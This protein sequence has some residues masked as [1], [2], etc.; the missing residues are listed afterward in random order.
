MK[1]LLCSCAAFVVFGGFTIAHAATFT[2]TSV[3]DGIPD[4]TD[5]GFNSADGFQVSD[6]DD[7]GLTLSEAI[8]L[9]N[10]N[11]GDDTI[12]FDDG[13]FNGVSLDLTGNAA[14]AMVPIESNVTI[15]GS[16]VTGGL[17]I[18]GG[19]TNGGFFVYSGDVTIQNLIIENTHAQG[20]DGGDGGG[21]GGGGG[22]LGGAVFVNDLAT[23][24]L[25]LSLIHI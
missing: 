21:S 25:D 2:V 12:V 17:T 16:G 18:D 13:V 1:R 14:G 24:T 5:P 23:V 3:A 4:T 15:D 7:G 20:G 6:F 11:G 9:A 8:F 22:G 19:A 10:E